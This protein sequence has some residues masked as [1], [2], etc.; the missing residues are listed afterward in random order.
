MK[1]VVTLKV[2]GSSPTRKLAGSIAKGVVNG[3]SLRMRAIGA[4]AVNQMIKAAVV[5]RGFLIQENI[6]LGLVPYFGE[7]EENR[8]ASV[9]CVQVVDLNKVSQEVL[10]R[11]DDVS[12][13][14]E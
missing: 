7:P 6:N 11:R 14:S 3:E 13:G 12:V 1:P 8:E 9:V 10:K 5:A 2:R 4:G